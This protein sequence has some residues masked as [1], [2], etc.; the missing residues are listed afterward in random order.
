MLVAAILNILRN[1]HHNYYFIY[2][3]RETCKT[4]GVKWT[5]G[6]LRSGP[7]WDMCSSICALKM[8]ANGAWVLRIPNWRTRFR[9]ET[10]LPGYDASQRSTLARPVTAFVDTRDCSHAKSVVGRFASITLSLA[11]IANT[12]CAWTVRLGAAVLSVR[13]T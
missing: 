1:I 8:C 9:M 7:W 3:R 12:K 11:H 2:N 6:S 4:W 13:G 5:R 10:G